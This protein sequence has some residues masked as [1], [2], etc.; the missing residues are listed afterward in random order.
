MS[1]FFKNFPKQKLSF[2]QKNKDWRAAHLDWADRKVYFYD[3]SIRKS[4]I[5]KRINYNLVDGLLDL[6]DMALVLN[7][8]NIDASFIPENIQY[9]PIINSKLNV[10][11][12]EESKR[13]FDWKLLVTNPNA[14]AEIEENKKNELF[15]SLQE[16]IKAEHEDEESFNKEMD[17]M[18]YYYT[19][20]WQDAREERGNLLLNHYIKELEIKKT[21]NGGFNDA[22][23]VGEEIYQCDIVGGEPI[24]Q[25]VNP[26]KVHIFKNGYSDKIEDADILV[27]IDFWS[28]GRIIDTFYDVLT[29]KDVEYID[30]MPQIYYSDN[31]GN[32]DERNSFLNTADMNGFENGEGA[33]IDNYSIFAQNTGAA[34]TTNYYDNNGN[35]RVVRVYWKSKRKIKKIKSYNPETGDEEFDFYPE[36]YKCDKD[37]GQEEEIFW[38]NEAWE[39]AKIGRDI[40]VNMRPRIVQY[41]RLSNPSKCHFGFVGSLYNINDNKPFSLVDIMKPYAYLYSALHDRLNKAIAANWG[42]LV[43]LDLA[44]IPKGWEV[45]KW[46]YYAKINHIAVVDSF[47]EGNIGAATGKLSGMMQQSS[48]V[49]DLEQGNYIQQHINLLEFVKMEMSEAAGISKQREGQVSSN[50]TVGGVERATLQSSHITEW[51]FII[52]ESVKKRALECF[53]ETAK[54][55]LKGKTKKFQYILS[56]GAS[57]IADIDGDEFAECDY[58]LV[59]DNSNESQQLEQNLTQLAHAALQNQTI[60]MGSIVKILNSPSMAEVQRIIEKDEKDIQERK[61]KEA[62]DNQKMQQQEMQYRKDVEQQKMQLQDTLNQRDNETKILIAE[63]NGSQELPE[64]TSREELELKIKKLDEEMALKNTQHEHKVNQDYAQNRLKEKDLEI[65]KTNKSKTNG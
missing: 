65:K 55:A 4:F 52:H 12:G 61:S 43:K 51:L 27:Y 20:E 7:P 23:I 54:I 41:N 49:L 56:N 6:N 42:K 58:G 40:Y 22:M 31:M 50:E 36:T 18:S 16:S 46:M 21:F 13:R 44:M 57:K 14:I 53:L 38:I 45:D 32:I 17:K 28:P 37:L 62:Q 1:L 59:V 24:L 2:T 47:K 30:N 64:D 29:D 15:N 26:L 5:R 25:R 9:Y 34:A 60:S 63:M 10:L 11:R 19:Y 39:G 3:N 8:D 33:I 35:I 48:G